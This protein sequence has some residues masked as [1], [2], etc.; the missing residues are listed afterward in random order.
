MQKRYEIKKTACRRAVVWC[1]Y[2]FSIWLLPAFPVCQ[3]MFKQKTG[4]KPVGE[5]IKAD[6]I[7]DAPSGIFIAPGAKISFH[8]EASGQIFSCKDANGINTASN[9]DGKIFKEPEKRRQQTGTSVDGKHP[10]RGV[11]R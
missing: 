3:K 10:Q 8:Q 11:P 2:R 4:K 1:S 5:K 9:I 6:D 7:P